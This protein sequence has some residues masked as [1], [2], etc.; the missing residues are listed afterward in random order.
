MYEILD[1]ETFE[2]LKA[3]VNNE[4]NPIKYLA[5]DP[6]KSNGVCGYDDRYRLQFMLVVNAQDMTKFLH[7]FENVE[8]CV[9]ED[10]KLYPNKSKQ[11]AYSDM[12]TS[13]VIG[14]IENW[15]ELKDVKIVKQLATI[16]ETGY[17]WLGKKPLPK[18]DKMNHGMDAHVHFMYWAIRTGKIPA[19]EVMGKDASKNVQE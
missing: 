9:L 15:A 14:R 12:E 3:V 13:R 1:P 4:F 5:V 8:T 16:K 2:K 7:S 18:S 10:F 6:G 17:K 19:A 11:Q